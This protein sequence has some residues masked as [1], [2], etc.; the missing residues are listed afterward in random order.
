MIRHTVVFTLKHAEG[1]PEERAFM[2]AAEELATINTV[3]KFEQ[4]RQVSAKCDFAYGFSMEFAD[5]AAYDVYNDH[6]L[7]QAFVQNRWMKEVSAFQEIDYRPLG[8]G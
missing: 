1:S 3:E 7:H 6:P 4:L 5:Q 2:K 8:D